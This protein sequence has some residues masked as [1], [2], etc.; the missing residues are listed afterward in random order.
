MRS[1]V[2]AAIVFAAASPALALP[3]YVL[4][5]RAVQ[6]SYRTHRDPNLTRDHFDILTRALQYVSYVSYFGIR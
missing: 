2:I 1:S 3:M 5:L 4:K 6:P